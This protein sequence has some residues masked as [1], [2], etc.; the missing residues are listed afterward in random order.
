MNARFL[1]N[2]CFRSSLWRRTAIVLGMFFMWATGSD[3]FSV[4]STE[5]DGIVIDMNGA[6]LSK[7]D[8]D[9]VS[10]HGEKYVTQTADDGSYA[11]LVPPGVYRLRASRSGFCEERR[12]MIALRGQGKLEFN[13]QL[14]IC[15]YVDLKPSDDST[16]V[17][18]AD[19]SPRYHGEEV[20]PTAPSGLRPLISYG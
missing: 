5:L 13:F 4:K 12:A 18:M 2:D 1:L 7:A 20:G 11:F 10:I 8:V 9:A 16:Y 19:P 6:R 3:S 14:F 17:P 15:P